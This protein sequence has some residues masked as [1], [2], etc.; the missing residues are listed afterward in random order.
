M[1]RGHLYRHSHFC[2]PRLPDTSGELQVRFCAAS[3]CR[4]VYCRF[5]KAPSAPL[6]TPAFLPPLS[7]SAL[8]PSPHPPLLKN[9]F[10]QGAPGGGRLGHPVPPELWGVRRHLPPRPPPDRGAAGGAGRGR[11]EQAR[12]TL[13]VAPLCSLASDQMLTICSACRCWERPHRASS[14][15]LPQSVTARSLRKRSRPE[16]NRGTPAASRLAR[17]V[18]PP[19]LPFTRPSAAP[20]A[21]RPPLPPARPSLCHTGPTSR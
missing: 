12:L 7:E 17:T 18:L 13:L 8:S 9:K 16:M 5:G 14:P 4:R 10:E 15:L 2:R 20:S 21:L 3:H 1:E 19:R 6:L 11:A